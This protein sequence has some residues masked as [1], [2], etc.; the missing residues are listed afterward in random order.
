MRDGTRAWTGR[1]GNEV[2]W[3]HGRVF[4]AYYVITDIF[5]VPW[6][7][8]CVSC[9]HPPHTLIYETYVL[10]MKRCFQKLTSLSVR[11][12]IH[13]TLC[14]FAL[15]RHWDM[16]MQ[17]FCVISSRYVFFVFTW[18]TVYMRG[19]FKK[20]GVIIYLSISILIINL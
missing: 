5:P 16:G 14:N 2:L 6:N 11:I 10:C 18:R 8:Y 4:N 9:V 1:R 3:K 12:K 7:P 20:I 19:L 17:F 13:A 15:M